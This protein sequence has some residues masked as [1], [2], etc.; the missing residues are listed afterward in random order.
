MKKYLLLSVAAA[1]AAVPALANEPNKNLPGSDS[2]M[3]DD[4]VIQGA[5]DSA[6]GSGGKVVEGDKTSPAQ[7]SPGGNSA[8][9]SN[10][11]DGVNKDATEGRASTDKDGEKT[12][13]GIET[14]GSGA[15]KRD[16]NR[17]PQ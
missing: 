10:V 15:E 2:N 7:T 1:F 17:L 9:N 6:Q 13:P 3:R 14:P 11:I 8:D 4:N 12:K 16:D 5:K